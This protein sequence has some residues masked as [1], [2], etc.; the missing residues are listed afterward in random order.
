MGY[1]QQCFAVRALFGGQ[2]ELNYT[3]ISDGY[4]VGADYILEDQT[5]GTVEAVNDMLGRL[6][7]RAIAN[8]YAP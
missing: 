6:G 5:A 4:T 1:H 8:A 3:R 2:V 7:P